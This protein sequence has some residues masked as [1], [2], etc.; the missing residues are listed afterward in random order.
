MKPWGVIGLI[1]SHQWDV[2]G[3]NK[4]STSVTG[5]QY[6]YSLN[7]K[8]GWVFGAGPT[9]S[10]NHKADSGNRW[11][12]P[13]GIGG[14]KTALLGGRPWKFGL[15]YWYY[16]KSPDNFGP[17]HQIRLQIAPVMKLPW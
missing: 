15:Q 1:A 4:T 8:D 6:F 11:T 3:S 14:S 13:V 16:V 5:G 12:L 7:L 17:E 10:Y 9:F 2:G